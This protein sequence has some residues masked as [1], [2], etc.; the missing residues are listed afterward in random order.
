MGSIT[1]RSDSIVP[2]C[3]FLSVEISPV[4]LPS[5]DYWLYSATL[6]LLIV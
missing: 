4:H 3:F 1:Y 2:F 5:A 6:I